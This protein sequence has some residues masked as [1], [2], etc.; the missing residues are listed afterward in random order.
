MK[1]YFSPLLTQFL[2]AVLWLVAPPMMH[3]ATAADN[4]A[5]AFQQARDDYFRA[6]QG[7]VDAFKRA[8]LE[9]GALHQADPSGA[10][11][12]AYW[13]SIELLK[14]AHTFNI[15]AMHSLTREGLADLDSAVR[16][17]PSNIEVRYIRGATEYHLPFFL[18]RRAQAEQDFAWIAP[19]AEKAV[20]QGQLPAAL[21]A[22]ALDI[23]GCI[24]LD[25]RN[26]AQAKRAFENAR[27]IAPNSPS[28]HD[29]MHR[30]KPLS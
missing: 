26:R 6:L 15:F 25:Q 28:G 13:G 17:E 16:Q 24:L 20:Q 23:Y 12:R 30:L 11:I 9:F 10:R 4:P 1:K 27:Q 7:N 5:T 18:H 14:A 8:E 22:S 2:L 29:A 19:Q 3:A 21:A